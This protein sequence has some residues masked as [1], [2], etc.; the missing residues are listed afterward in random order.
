MTID[1][2]MLTPDQIERWL[3]LQALI[4]RQNANNDLTKQRRDYYDGKQ[5]IPITANQ[6]DFLGLLENA[7]VWSFNI[8]AQVVDA[9]CERLSVTGFAV[10]GDTAAEAEGE[11]ATPAAELAAL[12]WQW[13]VFSDL[14]SLQNDLYRKAIRDGAAFL[15]VTW[16]EENDRPEFFVN[17]LDD[18]SAGVLVYRDGYNNK[19]VAYSKYWWQTDPLTPGD[20][21]TERKTVYL[22]G[23]VRKYKR[24]AGR[25]G[26]EPVQD[27]RDGAWPVQWIGADGE[28]LGFAMWVFATP[29]GSDM[30]VSLLSLQDALN[31]IALDVLAASAA[32]GFPIMSIE[33]DASITPPIVGTPDKADDEEP[34]LEIAPGRFV[35]LYGGRLNQIRAADLGPMLETMWSIVAAMSATSNVPQYRLRPMGGA[36]VPS[37]EALKQ[38]ESALVSKVVERQR[39]YTSAWSGVMKVAYRLA[40]RYSRQQLPNVDTKTMIVRPV[41]ADPNVRNEASQAQIAQAHA[42]LGVP[43]DVIWQEV[44]GYSPEQVAQFVEGQR[45]AEALKIATIAA[46][47]RSLQTQQTQAAVPTAQPATGPATEAE[48]QETQP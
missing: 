17:E 23:Q 31:T 42:A 47:M 28:P 7:D 43:Q 8:I 48:Q 32:A 16:N 44:L 20:Q 15:L 38:L 10:N 14:E 33:Y 11:G 35:E 6:R 12:M 30:T 37:G 39:A 22:P 40:Q 18:G 2:R 45:Q 25:Y 4:D 24:G 3:H 34:G 19:P 13:W 1:L 26:W 5:D 41:W 36:D 46:Q 21:G 29:D 9:V 27:P